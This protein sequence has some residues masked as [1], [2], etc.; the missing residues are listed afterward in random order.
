[1]GLSKSRES[2]AELMTGK[3]IHVAVGVIVEDGAILISRRASGQHQGGLWEF[4]GGKVEHGESVLTA[5]TRELKEE[6]AIDVLDARPLMTVEH[7]YEDKRVL[8]DVWVVTDFSGTP[9]A[10]E[11]QPLARVQRRDL[12]D[13][14]FPEANRPIVEKLQ[15]E[16]LK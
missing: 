2:R 9:T 16:S 5:L 12:R 6:L 14:A 15:T 10:L 7:D 1:M 8:L 3:R 4:P 13:Y 11:S